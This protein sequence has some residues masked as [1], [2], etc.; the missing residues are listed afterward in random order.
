MSTSLLTEK[1]TMSSQVGHASDSIAL[2]LDIGA[3]HLPDQRF[4]AS[5]GDNE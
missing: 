4:K 3:Q 2:N 5:E 1:L